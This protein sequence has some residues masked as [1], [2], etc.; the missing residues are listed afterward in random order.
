MGARFQ[1]LFHSPPGVLFTF[2]SRYWCAIGHRVVLRLG[3]WSTQVR[4]GFH[5]P[6][7]TQGPR[8]AVRSGF[9]YGA[10]TRCGPTFQSVRLA[11]S[12]SWRRSYNPARRIATPA[13][14]ALP[15]SLATTCGIIVIFSSY[16]Y[17]DVSVPHVRLPYGM[18]GLLPAGLPHSETH[19]SRVTCTSP[20]TIAAY[21]VLLRLR[22]PR[23]PPRALNRS[24][25]LASCTF[26]I[27]LV[28][29]I[30]TGTALCYSTT[31]LLRGSNDPL[32]FQH[33]KELFEF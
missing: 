26:I 9:A 14:W 16:G 10:V 13:V 24:R 1:V 4:T 7:P 18:T 27:Y 23:H 30:T 17:L 25:S 2:P 3:W 33:V 5:V 31:F 19:G 11:F 8:R 15:R 28:P 6:G 12:S 32:T 29:C 21:R 20:W 22:E